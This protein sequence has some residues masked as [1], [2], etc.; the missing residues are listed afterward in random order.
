MKY[1]FLFPLLTIIILQSCNLNQPNKFNGVIPE[2]VSISKQEGY[3]TIDSSTTIYSAYPLLSE[4]GFLQGSLTKPLGFSPKF[5]GAAIEINQIQFYVDTTIAKEGYRLDITDNG[6][7]V[8][9]STPYGSFYAVQTILQLLPADVYKTSK[10][11]EIKWRIPNVSINDYP[12]Y[13]WRGVMLDVSRQFYPVAFI[14]R[15]IDWMAVHKINLFHW[16]LT[17]DEGWRID[18]VRYP[19]LTL[20]GAYRGKNEVLAPAHGSGDERYGGF[21]TMKEIKEVVEY[22]KIRKINV[23]PEIDLPGHSKAIVASYPETFCKT[24][25][26]SASVQNIKQ[27]VICP[28][29]PENMALIDEIINEIAFLFPFEYVHIGGD[30]VNMKPWLSCETCSQQMKKQNLTNEIELKSYF[31][32]QLNSILKKHGKKLIGWNEIT[33][34]QKLDDAATMAWMNVNVAEKSIKM[35]YPTVLAPAPYLYFDMKHTKF[36]RG[37]DWAGITDIEK[38][39]S[40]EPDALLQL[41]EDE[42]KLVLG[43]QGQ[44]WSEYM[45][46]PRFI[47]YQSYPRIAAL[48]EIGWS[49]AIKRNWPDFQN[50]LI[51]KHEARMENL[52]IEYRIF[53]PT[54]TYSN[55]QFTVSSPYKDAVI[56]YTTDGSEP[57]EN[58]AKYKSPVSA[59]PEAAVNYRFKLF[60][61][62]GKK[63]AMVGY[64]AASEK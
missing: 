56:R 17:D 55:N 63:S 24:N 3:F 14:K 53:A 20:K 54:L 27:N 51:N 15:Y 40:Y 31:N 2:P 59:K 25:D 36:E 48:A 34:G 23:L 1:F 58:A 33:D 7:K 60:K 9:A 12:R 35:G 46:V 52:G 47:E 50:R 62:D 30:E 22:A 26:T 29:R 64:Q 37:Q 13:A 5:A 57:T 41:T 8:Y 6:I 42:K 16:H 49:P 11:N 32:Q 19:K 43:V 44:L 21:Y 10:V 45:D 28:S 39:Y 4:A 38:T 61:A 18:I